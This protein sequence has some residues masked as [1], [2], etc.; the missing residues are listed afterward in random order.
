MGNNKI[1]QKQNFC[2]S[3]VVMV[4]SFLASSCT[5]GFNKIKTKPP[6][7]CPILVKPDMVAADSGQ[8]RQ[9]L[10]TLKVLGG[11]LVFLKLLKLNFSVNVYK[12][13]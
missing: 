12:P 7:V 2:D 1:K 3:V 10:L 9:L 4:G 13:T 8:T 11:F 5:Q 6:A